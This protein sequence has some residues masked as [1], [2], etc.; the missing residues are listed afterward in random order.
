MLCPPLSLRYYV[1]DYS[2]SSISAYTT[3]FI[4]DAAPEYGVMRASCMRRRHWFSFNVSL[5]PRLA[6]RRYAFGGKNNKS[7][8]GR[9]GEVARA[10]VGLRVAERVQRVFCT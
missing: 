7:R 4:R 5:R 2:D 1:R 10:L 6:R 9:P 3:N 8:P